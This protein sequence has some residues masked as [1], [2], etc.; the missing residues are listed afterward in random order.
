MSEVSFKYPKQ[1]FKSC[2]PEI[3]HYS[4][5][6][7]AP[8][9]LSQSLSVGLIEIMIRYSLLTT[10]NF[11]K[12]ILAAFTNKQQVSSQISARF[13]KSED[14]SLFNGLISQLSANQY[15]YSERNS[16]LNF[17]S[18]SQDPNNYKQGVRVL[19]C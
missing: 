9:S 15:S 14:Y 8:S 19:G 13:N 6:S 3:T 10:K 7:S 16:W 5:F 1:A 4:A 17:Y 12:L 2:L 11:S 18:E